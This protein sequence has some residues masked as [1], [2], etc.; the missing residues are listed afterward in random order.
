MQTLKSVATNHPFTFVLGLTIVWFVSALVVTGIASSVLG[1]P[2]GDAATVTIGRLTVTAC[3][4]LLVWRLGWLEASGVARLGR[5]PVWL[6]ALGGMIYFAG[7]SL[8]S[9]YDKVAFDFLSLIRLPASRTAVLAQFAAGL[10]EEIM[11]RGAALY[12][13][14]RVWGHRKQGM[15]GGVVLTSL[16]FAVLHIMHVFAYGVPLS[17]VLILVVE[18]W[19]VSIWW[20]ALVLS[21]GSIWPAVMLHFVVNAVVAVQGLAVPMIEPD[22]LVYQR[23]LWFSIP[24]GLLG[25]GLLVRAPHRPVVPETA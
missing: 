22:T 9:F 19:I 8:Y 4:L 17:L 10:S 13:L 15:I 20:A 16:L 21:G 18:T 25:I 1:M 14:V 5:W 11:F 7:A 24:L 6:L 12:A 3:V 2:Y 23:L